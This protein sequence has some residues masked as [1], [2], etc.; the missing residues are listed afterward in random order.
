MKAYLHALTIAAILPVQALC[1]PLIELQNPF[2]L[3]DI[4]FI[5][6]SGN[7]IVQ[8]TA[9]I[10]LEDG[11]VKN[12]AGFTIELLPSAAYADERILKT[13]RNN[14]RDQILMSEQPPRF[15]PDDKRY[16]DNVRKTQCD[17]E[18]RF[19]FNHVAAGSYYVMAFIIWSED[20]TKHGGGVMRKI[21]VTADG[22]TKLH[23][24]S[25]SK[26]AKETSTAGIYIQGL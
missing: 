15:A 25:D 24:P 5:H 18:G 22:N 1:Q 10:Q 2:V 23:A 11:S 17:S 8:G 16:H 7:A 4:Q 20:D 21:A 9:S 19:A 14:E 6:T 26:A 12:C 13:Y 3:E